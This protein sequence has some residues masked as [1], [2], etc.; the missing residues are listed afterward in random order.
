MKRLHLFLAVVGVLFA[1]CSSEPENFIKFEDANTKKLCIKHWD[2]NADGEL[3]HAEAAAVTDIGD[4]FNGTMITSFNELKHFTGLT[5]IEM[6]AFEDCTSLKSIIIPDGVTSIGRAAFARCSSLQSITI[7]N[8]VAAIGNYAFF[9]CTGEL[10]IDSKIVETDYEYRRRPSNDGWL[11]G[12]QFSMLTIGDNIT[13]IGKY[14]FGDCTSLTSVTIP[15]SVTEIAEYAF[16]D[17]DSL[18]D[19]YVI[20]KDLATYITANN[21]AY[22]GGNKHLLVNGKEITELVIPDGV[23]EIAEYAFRDCTSLTSVTIPYSVT[24]IGG[25]AFRGCTSLTSVTIPNSVTKIGDSA[26]EDCTSLTSV[27]IPDSVTSIGD[28]AFEDCTSLYVIIKDLATYITANH[29][30]HPGGN[31]HLL[32]NGKEIT[33]LVIP[34]G[35]TK[36]GDSAFEDCTS[37]T[38]VTIPDSVTSIGDSAF[39]RCTSLI[40]VTIGKGVIFIRHYAFSKCT[41]LESVYCKAMRVPDG[42]T[43]MFLFSNSGLK[44]YVPRSKAREYKSLWYCFDSYIVGHDF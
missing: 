30:A 43:D 25:S 12:A 9:G 8:S 15:D 35:V 14:A 42:Y 17:C 39:S 20:I 18:T 22:P 19:T 36:I 33:E 1:S 28:S 21:I 32:V 24:S 26:F 44:I 11:D 7:P 4:I 13:A 16:Y 38:S 2:A 37:L 29:I 41:S 3:S 31:K 6:E 34:D 23:T 27:T 10:I 5:S 40:S